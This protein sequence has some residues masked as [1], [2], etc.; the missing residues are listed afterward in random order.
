MPDRF[1]GSVALV[2]GG[3]KGIGRAIA[4][5]LASEGASVA[6]SWFRD[7][8]A[9]EKTLAQLGELGSSAHAVKA[10]LGDPKTAARVVEEV[11]ASMGEPDLLVSNAASGVQRPLSEIEESHWDWTM[12]TNA[13]ALLRLVQSA[14]NLKAI[15]ALTSLGSSRVL[16]GYGIVGAS[17]AALES[18]TRYLAVELAPRCRVN[19]ISAGVVDTESLRRFPQAKE[20]LHRA[21]QNTPSGRLVRPEDVA[22][23]AAF[24]LSEEAKMITGQTV[25]IDGGYSVVG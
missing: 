11:R 19:A 15:V 4:L 5:R 25:V 17:K 6:I 10:H 14:P 23:L 9:A 16:A 13:A 1:G 8:P 21:E 20:I 7:R 24:L 22:D 12:Q 18:L 3:S 2:T